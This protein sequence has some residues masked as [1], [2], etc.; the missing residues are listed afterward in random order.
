MAYRGMMEC[1]VNGCGW[2]HHTIKVVKGTAIPPS[3]PIVSSSVESGASAVSRGGETGQC[4]ATK[5][6]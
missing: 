1:H 6:F 2:K 4:N 5:M 3:N